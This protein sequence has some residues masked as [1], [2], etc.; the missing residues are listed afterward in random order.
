MGRNEVRV[1]AKDLDRVRVVLNLPRP[2]KRRLDLAAERRGVSVKA[3]I[4]V[5]VGDKL[6]RIPDLD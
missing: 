3:L 6:D 4:K 1:A 5:W 2:M